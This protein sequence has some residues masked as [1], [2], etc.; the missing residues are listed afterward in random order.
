MVLYLLPPTRNP[1]QNVRFRFKYGV[2]TRIVA[3]GQDDNNIN[4]YRNIILYLGTGVFFDFIFFSRQI[5]IVVAYDPTRG[6]LVFNKP[7]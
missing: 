1:I 3:V 2:H 6:A 7:L 4:Q 5:S